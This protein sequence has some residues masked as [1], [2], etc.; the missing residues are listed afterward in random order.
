[1]AHVP[2]FIDLKEKRT[3]IFGGGHVGERK[4]KTFCAHGPTT[5]VSKG[6]TPQLVKMADAG[7]IE[8]ITDDVKNVTPYLTDAFI[9]VPATNNRKLNEFI[10]DQAKAKGVLV[11]QVD[12]IGEV[13]VPSIISREDIIVGISTMGRSPASARFMRL[14]IQ[15]LIDDVALM[16]GLQNHLRTILKTEIDS[17]RERRRLLELIINDRGVWMELGESYEAGL[18]AA[19]EIVRNEQRKQR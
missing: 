5:V 13:I 4:A 18:R 19:L 15:E 9:A 3:V 7:L 11:N 1:M 6:F 17:Q 2:L 14:K 16:V 10:A 8:V 12:G